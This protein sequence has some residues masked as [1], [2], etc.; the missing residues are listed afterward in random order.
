MLSGCFL[1]LTLSYIPLTSN[2]ASSPYKTLS[3]TDQLGLFS[4]LSPG[5]ATGY[6][7]SPSSRIYLFP[8]DQ[9]YIAR[10]S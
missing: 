1:P 5:F 3:S 6:F 10:F 9:Q 7:S 8:K 2:S 4:E